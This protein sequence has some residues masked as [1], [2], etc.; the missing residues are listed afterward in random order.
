MSMPAIPT[1]DVAANDMSVQ[2]LN[3]LFGEGWHSLAPGGDSGA[4]LSTATNIF[5][6][7]LEKLN[8]VAWAGVGILFAYTMAIGI[9]GTAHSGEPLGKRYSTLWTPLRF[10]F[11][12]AML[13]PVV[14][15]LS[16]FQI[17]ILSCVG[18]SVNFANW[19]WAAGLDHLQETGG[20][21]STE[22]PGS[23]VQEGYT[24]A[25]GVLQSLVLQEHRI[26]REGYSLSGAGVSEWQYTVNGSGT[27]AY[28]RLFQAPVPDGLSTNFKDGDY[29]SVLVVC[30]AG[31]GEGEGGS[32]AAMSRDACTAMR[33]AVDGLISD[34]QPLA[35]AVVNP[36]MNPNPQ[37]FLTSISNYNARYA[38]AMQSH[39]LSRM[40]TAQREELNA[41]VT[42]A[43]RQGWVTAGNYYW[44]IARIN[45]K[46]GNLLTMQASHVSGS[47][48]EIMDVSLEIGGSMRRMRKLLD[49]AVGPG[50]DLDRME[51]LAAL[52]GANSDS[53]SDKIKGYISE[54]MRWATKKMVDS[55]SGS[56]DPLVAMSSYGHT[57]ISIGEGAVAG[58]VVAAGFSAAME[59][60]EQALDKAPVAGRVVKF[61]T[62]AGK[63]L[64]S[65][66]GWALLA[67]S[68]PILMLGFI[69]AYYLPALPFIL[70]LSGFCGW[71]IL[72]VEALVAA[73][74]WI[75]GHAMPEG[76]GMA[77]E[78]GKQGYMLMFNILM[79]PPL[80]VAGVWAALFLVDGIAPWLGKAMKVFMYSVTGGTTYGLFSMFAMMT[81]F[82]ILLYILSH[83]LFGLITHLPKSII[84]WIG[85]GVVELGERDDEGR[86]R[87]IFAA[88]GHTTQSAGNRGALGATRATSGG[89]KE[90]A[91]AHHEN[92]ALKHVRDE[93]LVQDGGGGGAGGAKERGED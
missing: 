86:A 49:D 73:P 42:M 76:E 82:T 37:W 50:G 17:I 43:K 38:G 40:S 79:R 71:I 33:N 18:F 92:G 16:I 69:W 20:R 48:Q 35:R 56:G 11:A 90:T 60:A 88:V 74:L 66:V 8:T 87:G 15:G 21:V 12:N 27:A 4:A 80:M 89:K 55:L 93:D 68:L 83:K 3:S 2:I 54:P 91:E 30:D 70:F 51:N 24:L 22:I 77:G 19:M 31:S 75:A 26:V 61:F 41:F 59:G 36:D 44:T 46:A 62:G 81:I 64:S 10:A 7:I 29:G 45:E 13:A 23:R 57:L 84:A 39:V 25:Q 5:Y 9:A 1:A 6:P 47:T 65:M 85:G 52:Q 34:L 32:M 14:K 67:L 28:R 63:A 53:L 58:A 72:V 78:R